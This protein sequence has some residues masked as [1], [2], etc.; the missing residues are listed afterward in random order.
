MPREIAL[1]T[2]HAATPGI[3]VAAE[4]MRAEGVD[5]PILI[6]ETTYADPVMYRALVEQAR[7][8]HIQIRAV[9]QWPLKAGNSFHISEAATPE[10]IYRPVP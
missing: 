4:D 7:F 5:L 8:Y 1:D 3:R 2:Y 10:Y 6:Q 9:M